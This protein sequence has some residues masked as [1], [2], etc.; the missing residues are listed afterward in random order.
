ML[1]IS[2]GYES[3]RHPFGKFPGWLFRSSNNSYPSISSRGSSKDPHKAKLFSSHCRH[4]KPSSKTPFS[5]IFCISHSRLPRCCHQYGSS[6]RRK[7]AFYTTGATFEQQRRPSSCQLCCPLKNK[8]CDQSK[9]T[10]D[11]WSTQDDLD[12]HT[13]TVKQSDRGP[14]AVQMSHTLL[15]AAK[16]ELVVLSCVSGMLFLN[17]KTVRTRIN[18]ITQRCLPS[19]G[20]IKSNKGQ[21]NKYLNWA[22]EIIWFMEPLNTSSL[23]FTMSATGI[24][25]ANPNGLRCLRG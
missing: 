3:L 20:K 1:H 16:H 19:F 22:P 2:F 21:A 6:G 25:E 12:K 13:H 14:G 10:G 4:C 17:L 23:W 18:L 7:W 15:I 9:A 24:L 5:D 11:T 8:Q